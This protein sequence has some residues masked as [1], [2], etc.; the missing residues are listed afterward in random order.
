MNRLKAELQDKLT[1]LIDL[2]SRARSSIDNCRDPELGSL[3]VPISRTVADDENTPSDLKASRVSD[4]MRGEKSSRGGPG[5]FASLPATNTEGNGS[6]VCESLERSDVLKS[7]VACGASQ[8]NHAVV[9]DGCEEKAESSRRPPCRA[10]RGV[11]S[12]D[13]SLARGGARRLANGSEGE[14]TDSGMRQTQSQADCRALACRPSERESHVQS[15]DSR[16][17]KGDIYEVS[18]EDCRSS[19]SDVSPRCTPGQH[20]AYTDIRC[21]R[22][23]LHQ[24]LAPHH[25]PLNVAT[26]ETTPSV[27]EEDLPPL[28]ERAVLA[29]E[30]LFPAPQ[31]TLDAARTPRPAEAKAKVH[32]CWLERNLACD[33]SLDERSPPTDLPIR[34]YSKLRPCMSNRPSQGPISETSNR[35]CSLAANG[36]ACRRHCVSQ[37]CSHSSYGSLGSLRTL[38]VTWDA[39]KHSEKDWGAV[40]ESQNAM[41]AHMHTRQ[42]AVDCPLLPPSISSS[43]IRV[44]TDE[45]NSHSDPPAGVFPLPPEPQIISQSASASSDVSASATQAFLGSPRFPAGSKMFVMQH[46][47]PIPQAVFVSQPVHAKEAP[48][49]T[50]AAVCV[51]VSNFVRAP[52]GAIVLSSPPAVALSSEPSPEPGS[53]EAIHAEHSPAFASACHRSKVSVPSA[54]GFVA[55]PLHSGGVPPSL[56]LLTD[57]TCGG[58]W[59]PTPPAPLA[60][61]GASQFAVPSAGLF[62]TRQPPGVIP[63]P[64]NPGLFQ[65]SMGVS[66]RSAPVPA[67]WPAS[68]SYLHYMDPTQMFS[69]V[70]PRVLRRHSSAVIVPAGNLPALPEN[71]TNALQACTP[72]RRLRSATTPGT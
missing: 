34:S 22:P 38:E 50:H 68:D 10:A 35:G 71:A 16:D 58:S 6:Y 4:P 20:N 45:S 53:A 19:R 49:T 65:G 5:R 29:G 47:P 59:L 14:R 26:D 44:A 18:L 7:G 15:I 33:V 54:S 2:I 52:P 21:E 61:T 31:A 40:D 56:R 67:M 12:Q 1:V 17:E 62:Q 48:L 39:R 41:I 30:G 64:Q 27:A 3:L 9:Q 32:A 25:S 51:P 46:H 55:P 60:H 63:C 13:T 42:G 37:H 24:G 57:S 43:V 69:S 66:L 23:S 8:W 70:H 36:D 28:S 72:I 11:K